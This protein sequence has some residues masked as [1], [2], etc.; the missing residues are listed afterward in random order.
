[1]HLAVFWQSPTVIPLAIHLPFRLN[2]H[3]ALQSKCKSLLCLYGA[4]C[5]GS[6]LSK[7]FLLTS[8]ALSW[9]K[10]KLSQTSFFV[11]SIC[12]AR[13]VSLSL[14]LQFVFLHLISIFLLLIKF[15]QKR[16]FVYFKMLF[17]WHIVVFDLQ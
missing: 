2:K 13:Q 14:Y 10:Q 9:Q 6:S 3:I 16:L 17:Y 1:M 8:T 12:F 7:I 11:I 4:I 5:G 15:C